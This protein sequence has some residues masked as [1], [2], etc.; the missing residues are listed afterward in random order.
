MHQQNPTLE[1]FMLGTCRLVLFLLFAACGQAVAASTP[2]VSSFPVPRQGGKWGYLQ[3]AATGKILFAPR[4]SGLEGHSASP[5]MSIVPAP[6]A[7]GTWGYVDAA[8]GKVAIAPQFY[9]AGFFYDGIAIVSR[10]YPDKAYEARARDEQGNARP[11]VVVPVAEGLIDRNGREI[12]PTLY[13]LKRADSNGAY[14]PRL[15]LLKDAQG[16]M[17]VLHADKGYVVPPGACKEFRFSREGSVFCGGSY[18]EPDG[19]RH[20]PPAGSEITC[21]ESE[22]RLFRVEQNK[23]DDVSLEG[24]MRRDGSLLVPVKYHNID[25]A[26]AAGVWLA[27]RID[28]S[29]VG[30]IVAA[31]R[32]GGTPDISEGKDSL[33]VDV[34]DASGAVLRSFRAGE[35]P[36][37]SGEQCTYRSKGHRYEVNAR[38]GEAVPE[39]EAPT[40]PTSAFQPFKQNG[41]YGIKNA[42]GSVSVQALYDNLHSL[43]NGLFAATRRDVV[44]ENTWGVIDGKG[45]EIIPF[46]Y[47]GIEAASYPTRSTGPLLCNRYS[48]EGYWLLGRDGRFITPRDNPYYSAVYFNAVG[49]AKVYRNGKHGVID[50]TGKV[51]IPIEYSTV[52]DELSLRE[53]KQRKG[54]GR[55]KSAGD[56]AGTAKLTAKDALYRVERGSLWGLYDGTGK[57]LI[58]IQYGH[59]SLDALGDSNLEQGW[60]KVE[61]EGRNNSGVANFRTGQTIAPIYSTVRVYPGFFLAYMHSSRTENRRD[62]YIMLDRRGKEGARYDRA[63]WL[64]DAGLLAARADRD[65]NYALLNGTGKQLFPA[66]CE[67]V[68]RATASFVWCGTDAGKA[69]VDKAGREYRIR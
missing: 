50:H 28:A 10:A 1:S 58:P 35:Y 36:S 38:T 9:E 61:D 15:F 59:I 25:A 29:V 42:D 54:T 3:D 44:Y 6:D 45:R 40:D 62:L 22:T 43:G 8:T 37:V 63:E 7:K 69:L 60:V 18:Y 19:R 56:N 34:Y 16:A 5:D 27:S 66:R 17:A 14:I 20:T 24:V 48:S 11:A 47:G 23:K 4:F 21:V 46:I 31:V 49:L 12:L 68:R 41:K 65:G 32:R 13:D 2:D 26:P 55:E 64:E 57:E 53:G 51:V 39:R 33:S 67:N 52:F 30:K